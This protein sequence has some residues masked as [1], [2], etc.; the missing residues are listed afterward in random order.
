MPQRAKCRAIKRSA[1]QTKP[2][3]KVTIDS[4]RIMQR[5]GPQMVAQSG[6]DYQLHIIILWLAVLYAWS[7]LRYAMYAHTHKYGCT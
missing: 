6:V 4:S 1:R 2:E 3:V 5:Y 7:F